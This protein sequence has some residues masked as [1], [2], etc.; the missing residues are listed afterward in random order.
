M[1]DMSG[2]SVSVSVRD[3][4]ATA[5]RDAWLHLIILVYMMLSLAWNFVTPIFEAPDEPDH[6]QYVLFVAATG[7]RPDLRFDIQ[8]AGIEAPQP[9]LYYFLMGAVVRFGGLA[10]PFKHPRLN[11]EFDFARAD[12]AINYYLPDTDAY[13]YVHT[14]RFCST[15]YG[16]IVIICTYLVT[17]MWGIERWPRLVAASS[18]AW[19]PQFTFISASITNDVLTSAVTSIA[20]I[21]LVRL[22]QLATPRAWQAALFGALCGGAFLGKS[23]AI[24]VLPFGWLMLISVRHGGFRL[25]LTQMWWSLVGFCLVSGWYLAYNQLYYGDFTAVNMQMRIVPELIDLKTPIDLHTVAY[26]AVGLPTL[27]YKSFLGVFGWMRLY[28]PDVFYLIFG[29]L[30]SGALTGLGLGVLRRSWPRCQQLLISGPLMAFMVIAY[31]NL[32]FTAPQGRYF[33]PALVIISLIFV[34]GV[35]ELPRVV[36]RT[37]LI[38]TPL[39]LFATNVYSLWYVAEAYK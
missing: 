18:V 9:P 8:Q 30:W 31:V 2:W 3:A 35:T 32:T 12:S 34:L 21:W 19:L 39:V 24:F 1:G 27:L 29:G 6:L 7:R 5:W 37:I 36:R 13:T 4:W 33:F 10:T 20:L 15:L 14:L 28:L 17:V 25:W 38:A 16:T 22:L 26:L 11:P 23:Q